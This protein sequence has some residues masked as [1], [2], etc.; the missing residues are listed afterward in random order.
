MH[1][2][3]YWHRNG[4]VMATVAMVMMVMMTA[5]YSACT[6]GCLQVGTV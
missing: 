4:T 6:A 1:V 2:S 3:A 5:V